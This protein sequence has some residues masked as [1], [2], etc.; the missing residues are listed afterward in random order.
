M[1]PADFGSSPQLNM[2]VCPVGTIGDWNPMLAIAEEML[3]RGHRVTMLGNEAFGD[4]A[5]SLG[6]E[7]VSVHGADRLASLKRPEFLD[8]QAGYRRHLPVQCLEPLAQTYA[9]IEARYEP[10]RTVVVAANWCFAARVAQEKLGVP[11]ATMLTDAHMLRSARG[12]YRMPRPM[13]LGR[14][15]FPF[16]VRLQFWVADLLYIDPLCRD[17]LNRFRGNLGLKPIRRVLDT[18]S[19]SPQLLLGMFPDWWGPPQPEWPAHV[20]LCGFPVYD[21]KDVRPLSDATLNFLAEGEPPVVFSPG[22]SSLHSREYFVAAIEAC[23]R[24]KR[25]ALLITKNVAELPDVDAAQIHQVEYAPFQ[26]LLRQACAVVHQAGTGTVAA[27]MRAGLPHVSI[28]S[29]FNQPDLAV[30]LERLGIGTTIEPQCVSAD[31]LANALEK[32]LNSNDV[33]RRCR[34]VQARFGPPQ[35]AARLATDYVEQLALSHAR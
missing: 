1:P 4:A 31:R 18:W 6:A 32:V 34:E 26:S 12:I 35:E 8:Y 19:N 22:N 27:T 28:P 7:F 11:T 20:R 23:Q 13:L 21:G 16:Y 25:R 10:G 9:E 24:L 5:K 3:A 29:F 33:A 15:V 2:L 17:E 14:W 30:R